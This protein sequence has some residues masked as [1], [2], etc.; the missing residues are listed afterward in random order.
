MDVVTRVAPI[1]RED[2]ENIAVYPMDE[3]VRAGES[4]EV[5]VD[6]KPGATIPLHR[7]GVDAT[8]FIVGG[9]ATLLSEKEEAHGRTVT[10]GD[11]VFFE[12]NVGHGFNVSEEGLAFISRNGGI[13]DADPDSWDIEF[14]EE[15]V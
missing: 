9:R 6:A 8:M 13:V 7:H 4:Q 15:A 14:L 3:E 1:E 12:R 5:F 11:K 2:L 10:K